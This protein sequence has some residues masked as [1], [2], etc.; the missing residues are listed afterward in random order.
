M[1]ECEQVSERVTVLKPPART[2]FHVKC[3]AANTL[4]HLLVWC[5]F[6][7]LLIRFTLA[8]TDTL[9]DTHTHMHKCTHAHTHTQV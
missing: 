5:D 8:H 3:H 4:T 2:T 7:T 6:G 1:C 9:R